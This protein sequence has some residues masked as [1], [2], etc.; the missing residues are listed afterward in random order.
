MLRESLF[1]RH[2]RRARYCS[3]PSLAVVQSDG[4]LFLRRSRL[5]KRHI[6][7]GLVASVSYKRPPLGG[8]RLSTVE[9]TQITVSSLATPEATTW[10]QNVTLAPASDEKIQFSPLAAM[11]TA[12]TAHGQP[13]PPEGAT[14]RLGCVASVF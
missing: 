2:K 8:G 13:M 14:P 6:R 10:V 11:E 4:P 7:Y 9:V 1:R 5:R 3:N 12:G